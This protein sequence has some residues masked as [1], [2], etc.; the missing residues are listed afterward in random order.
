LKRKRFY[1]NAGK[2]SNVS[3][4]PVAGFWLGSVWA[5]INYMLLKG[6]EKYGF[7]DFAYQASVRYL[8]GMEAVYRKTGTVWE[9]YNPDEY[10]ASHRA[11]P[12]RIDPGD[13]G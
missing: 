11:A 3:K 13:P 1:L 8:R 2:L 9:N 4:Y 6:L 5:P 12:D 7:H 10:V